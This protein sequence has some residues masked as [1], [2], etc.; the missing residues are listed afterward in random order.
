MRDYDAMSNTLKYVYQLER[1]Y[2]SDNVTCVGNNQAGEE[3]CA[4]FCGIDTPILVCC[5]NGTR[6]MC[7]RPANN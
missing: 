5:N 1:Y 3:L 2:Q 7:P 4:D 6:G